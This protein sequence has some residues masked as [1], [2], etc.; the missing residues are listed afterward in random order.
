MK[1][2]K[3]SPGL[4]PLVLGGEKTS[5]WRLFDD[6]NLSV[7]D[8]LEFVNKETGEVFGYATITKMWEKKLG[9]VNDIDLD[10]HEKFSSKEE[11]IE[12]YRKYYGNEVNED[13]VVKIIHFTFTQK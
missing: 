4:V 11:M 12:T 13:T 5:T 9:E 2:I 8:N 1:T 6:K 10:G 3:F 7:D